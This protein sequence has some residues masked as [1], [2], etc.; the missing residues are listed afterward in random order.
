MKIK[1]IEIL[2]YYRII[3]KEKEFD[4]ETVSGRFIVNEN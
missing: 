1:Q 2:M 4:G 3:L